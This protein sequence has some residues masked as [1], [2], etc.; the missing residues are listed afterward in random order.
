[1]TRA[2]R[3]LRKMRRDETAAEFAEFPVPDTW[4]GFAPV[5]VPHMSAARGTE[6]APEP[7]ADRAEARDSR[8]AVP[9]PFDGR[10]C[11]TTTP[12]GVSETA[13]RKSEK[14]AYANATGARL[15][16]LVAATAAASFSAGR[17][18][19]SRLRA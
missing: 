14:S 2:L 16:L 9:A 6:P 18:W 7:A 1:M 4:A 17:F 3:A 10:R 11:Q 13:N 12:S 19:S 5:A 8:G 15:A